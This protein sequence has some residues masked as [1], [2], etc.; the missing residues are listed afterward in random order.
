MFVKCL[1]PRKEV[2]RRGEEHASE[3]N[4]QVENPS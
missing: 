1:S 3:L 2:V 4:L